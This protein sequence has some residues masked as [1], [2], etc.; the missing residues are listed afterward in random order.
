MLCSASSTSDK[1]F[2]LLTLYDCSLMSFILILKTVC[3]FE[4][5]FGS[6]M[7][8]K[9]SKSLQEN[10]AS[11]ERPRI[12]MWPC[13]SSSQLFCNS[14]SYSLPTG[15][16]VHLYCD[17]SGKTHHQQDHV[18]LFITL[19]TIDNPI[20]CSVYFFLHRTVKIF[21]VCLYYGEPSF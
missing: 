1:E 14:P 18:L 6:T 3:S 21:L 4:V 9:M 2:E 20:S 10:T 17:R 15:S 19:N 5:A 11:F 12:S 16:R 7:H 8:K 13:L